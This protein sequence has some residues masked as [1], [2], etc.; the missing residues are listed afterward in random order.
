MKRI[1]LIES[2]F[3][4]LFTYVLHFVLIASVY[5]NEVYPFEEKKEIYLITFE[6]ENAIFGM[7]AWSKKGNE[8]YFMLVK[9]V[10]YSCIWCS[11]NITIT[12]VFWPL[13]LSLSF[14]RFLLHYYTKEYIKICVHAVNAMN[15]IWRIGTYLSSDRYDIFAHRTPSPDVMYELHTI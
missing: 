11:I 12:T 10:W 15:F 13:F 14:T 9:S 3:S 4:S 7:Y 8:L 1:I 5:H 6:K 2:F